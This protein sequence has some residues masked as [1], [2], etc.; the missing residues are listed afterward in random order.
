M[1]QNI[2]VV[3]VGTTHP[4]N[5][6]GAARAMKNMGLARLVLVDPRIFPSPDADARASG[7][8]DILEGAQVVATLE[9]ALVGCR[10]VL[11][12]SAR[13]RSLPWPMLDPRGAGEKVI[14]QAGEGAE[15]ALVFG[16]E[17]SGL[18]NEELQRCHFHVHIPSDPAFSS[19]NLAAAVQVLSYEVRM[20]WLAV[21]ERGEAPKT[22]SAHSAELAT[23]DEMEGFYGHLETT[24]VDIGFL[25]PEKPR[26][27]M[28]RLRRLFGR[29][30]VERSELSI[31]RGVLTE[32]QKVARGEPYKRKDQ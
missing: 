19:L 6:G 25:D 3:L 32:T 9:E 30:E 27:L 12:T 24:L 10:L 28:A 23:M 29:S 7:A 15:V 8:T 22:A 2:R 1:L 17:H 21:S 13:D 4:G 16:R 14:E 26:H 5:I 18:T 31:L 20:A 11:G